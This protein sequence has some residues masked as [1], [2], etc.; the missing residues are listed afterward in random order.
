MDGL[1]CEILRDPASF[2]AVSPHWEEIGTSVFQSHSWLSAWMDRAPDH[3]PH[4]AVCWD[5]DRLAGAL[6]FAIHRVQHVRILEWMAQDFSDYCDCLGGIES[7][8]PLW[9]EVMRCGGFD[10]VRLKNIRGN[11]NASRALS[12]VWGSAGWHLDP[13]HDVCLRVD[14]DGLWSS[15][16]QWFR[17]LNKKKRN[18][19]LRGWR[20]LSET[21]GGNV[22]FRELLAD[23]AVRVLPRLRHFKRDWLKATQRSSPLLDGGDQLFDALVQALIASGCLRTFALMLG[24]RV[25]AGS[26]NIEQGSEMLAFFASYDAACSRASPGIL[27]MTEYTKW[28][29]DHGIKVVDYL[30]G[31]ETYKFEFANAKVSLATV[32]KSQT[33]LGRAATLGYGA[34]QAAQ[35][36]THR[37]P[38][39]EEKQPP[40]IGSAYETKNGTLRLPKA[41][42][43][44]R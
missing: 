35:R 14:S 28:A 16:D 2:R 32:V 15:G 21:V 37:R 36:I 9:R 22:E 25:I 29:F 40:A 4:V 8:M 39:S 33:M 12:P 30:R 27:L 43:T 3:R 20:I 17:T 19:H 18:N 23:E 1:R 13:D 34:V 6:P 31:D 7:V 10:V 44:V 42:D 38:Q 24:D 26:L 5:G 41:A 11:S